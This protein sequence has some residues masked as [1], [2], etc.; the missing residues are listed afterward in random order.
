[1]ANVHPVL[2]LAL[3]L[4]YE[5]LIPPKLLNVVAIQLNGRFQPISQKI[6]SQ[7]NTIHFEDK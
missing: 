1:M 2:E 5:Q 3:E 7:K 4:A 6:A